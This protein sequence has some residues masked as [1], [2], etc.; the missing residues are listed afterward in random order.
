MVEI[1]EHNAIL[2]RRRDGESSDTLELGQGG[3]QRK[4]LSRMRQA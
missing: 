3:V 1:V 4:T 2:L